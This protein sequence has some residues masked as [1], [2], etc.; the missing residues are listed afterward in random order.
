M[1]RSFSKRMV[2][3]RDIPSNVIEEAIFILKSDNEKG[4]QE[5]TPKG[6][7]KE[8]LIIKEAELL[9][10]NFNKDNEAH[11]NGLFKK[12]ID[13]KSYREFVINTLLVGGIVIVLYLAF[14][15]IS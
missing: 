10:N 3:L 1:T 7:K 12:L 5:G 8:F 4:L 13:K 11:I 15:V 6:K 9:V 2:V 14:K